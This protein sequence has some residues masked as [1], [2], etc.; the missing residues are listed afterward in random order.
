MKIS[1]VTTMYHSAPYLE[2]FYD[3]VHKSVT[4]ITQDYEMIFVNDGSPDNSLE[5]A[6]T[7]L[8][9]DEKVRII[10]LSRNFGHHKA[11]MTGLSHTNGDY[12]FLI[13]CDLEEEPELL[14][15]FYNELVN[16]DGLDVVYGIQDKRHGGWFKRWSGSLFY[17]IFNLLSDTKIPEDL[18]IGRV[19][20]RR[21]VENL[22]RHQEKELVFAGLCEL[23]GFDQKGLLVSKA[24]KGKT[25]YSIPKRIAI[26]VNS[27]TS[28]SN[29]PLILVFYLGTII[30]V[31]SGFFVLK[32]LM[33]KMLHDIPISGWTSLIVSI[34]FLSGL[35][36]FS[37]GIIGIYISKLFIEVKNRPYTIVRKIYSKE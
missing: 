26:I 4:K 5:I 36:L 21:Y 22:I 20:T 16:S 24:F 15:T 1:I 11:I 33:Q 29:K 31:I 7:L 8:D 30:S 3:R 14:E 34:W 18:I 2:E 9:K 23:T 37:L 28:F 32:I 13:D 10:D 35:V 17:K 27:V 12:V 25:S 19:M 6:L